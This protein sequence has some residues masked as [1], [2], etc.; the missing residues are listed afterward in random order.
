MSSSNLR[1]VM[2]GA[3]VA[4]FLTLTFATAAT[5]ADALENIRIAVGHI[6]VVPSNE[7]VTTVAVAEPD[8]ADAAVG[9]ARTVLVTAKKPGST[10]L[11]IYI[12]GGRYKVY[13][14]EV[15]LYNADKQVLLHCTVAEVN[16]DAI[17]ELGLDLTGAGHTDNPGL[18]GTLAGGVFNSHT[19]ATPITPLSGDL[20]FDG[21]TTDIV[22]SYLRNDGNLGFQT[23]IKALEAKGDIRLLAN[24]ALLTTSGE[25][26]SF[27]SGGEFAYQIVTGVGAGATPS[28]AFKEFG[29]RLVFTPYVQEDGSIRLQVEP[30]VSEPDWTR[31]VLGVPPLNTRKAS[32]LVTLNPGENLVIG[33]LKAEYHTKL[34]R[35]IPLLGQIPLLGALFSYSRTETTSKDLIFVVSPE[36]VTAGTARPELPTD[37][38][39]GK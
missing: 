5:A 15:Y 36:L 21:S 12:Q 8:I 6:A 7:D 16:S 38:A 17:R 23:T 27:L 13:N 26:A 24:P 22:L 37:R 20:R 39:G 35:K 31:S 14:V 10:N 1:D 33:G 29:V 2:R 11:V 4:L 28:I 18:N 19:M 3:A 25:K 32:T 34:S 9:S 30:E